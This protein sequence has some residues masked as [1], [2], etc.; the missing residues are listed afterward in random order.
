VTT[1][2]TI[3][4]AGRRERKKAATRASIS[5]EALRLFL[6]RG[7]HEVSLRDVAD[8]ADIAVT[9]VFKHFSGKEALVFD[10]DD[11]LEQALVA[12]VAERPAGRSVLD[13]LQAHLLQMRAVQGTGD[14]QFQPFFD[15]VSATPE[16]D[17]YWRRMFLRHTKALAE[18]ITR[19]TPDTSPATAAAIA[20]FALDAVDLARGSHDPAAAVQ[21]AFAVLRD[22][23]PH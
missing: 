18:A 16:L 2:P 5:R 10:E 15:L 14:P 8:A 22:G 7:Y 17:A 20:R 1:D 23:W 13:A 4:T 12:A 11:V 21:E 19:S 3:P 6:E 9:T